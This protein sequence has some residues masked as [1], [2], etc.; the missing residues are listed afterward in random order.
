[1]KLRVTQVGRRA[2][3][4]EQ[5]YQEGGPVLLDRDWRSTRSAKPY[6]DTVPN[7]IDK[8]REEAGSC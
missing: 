6:P 2:V 8:L 3:F 7:K 4:I 5:A 1:M